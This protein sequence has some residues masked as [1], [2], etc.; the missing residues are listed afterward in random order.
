MHLPLQQVLHPFPSNGNQITTLKRFILSSGLQ[1]FTIP[2]P[3]PQS[4]KKNPDAEGV[5][6]VQEAAIS[7]K[8]PGAENKCVG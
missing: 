3:P 8:I 7:I 5:S 1:S 4:R 6:L 2:T